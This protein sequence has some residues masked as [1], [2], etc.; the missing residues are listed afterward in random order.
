MSTFC[1]CAFLALLFASGFL[2]VGTQA[3][4]FPRARFPFH[5]HLPLI[6]LPFW[7]AVRSFSVFF[8]SPPRP[9][10]LPVSAYFFSRPGPPQSFPLFTAY[11]LALQDSFFSLSL[12][13]V[14]LPP[15]C[16]LSFFSC[17]FYFRSLSS[18]VLLYVLAAL[19][20]SAPPLFAL[21]W[22]CGGSPIRFSRV[23][24]APPRTKRP[25]GPTIPRFVCSYAALPL[26]LTPSP[27]GSATRHLCAGLITGS[28][29][30]LP[31][32]AFF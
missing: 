10:C 2:L 19:F 5:R 4:S 30:L 31:F 32:W 23:S 11:F 18:L 28:S 14:S 24:V 17:P 15:S 20:Y 1:S 9:F 12:L 22:L 27:T 8:P 26:I 3:D 7:L 21:S 25:P 13:T 29:L 16:A 6:K